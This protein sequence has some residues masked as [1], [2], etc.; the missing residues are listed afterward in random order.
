MLIFRCE[1]CGRTED[2]DV[3]PD[4]QRTIARVIHL[5]ERRAVEKGVELCLNCWDNYKTWIKTPRNRSLS[6]FR[7][8]MAK[9]A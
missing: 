3:M 5:Q 7:E 1:G 4:G 6:A 8:N 9:G 2:A